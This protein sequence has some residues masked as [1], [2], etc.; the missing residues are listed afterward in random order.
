[1]DSVRFLKIFKI[2]SEIMELLK[3]IY[4]AQFSNMYMLNSFKKMTFKYSDYSEKKHF[5]K[6]GHRNVFVGKKRL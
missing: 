3:F 5:G 6:D 2:D 1:M 4:S